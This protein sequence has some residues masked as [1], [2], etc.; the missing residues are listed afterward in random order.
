[1][2]KYV[3]QDPFPAE[4]W[5][6]TRDALEFGP[7]AAQFDMLTEI[8]DGSDDCLYLNVYTQSTETSILRPVMFW[9]HG[10]GFIFGS[11][12]DLFYGPDY[13]M[14]KDIVLV[15]VNYRLGVFGEDSISCTSKYILLR[16]KLILLQLELGFLNLEDKVAPGNQGLKDQVMALQWVHD[17]IKSFGGDPE[18]VTI[19]GE[20]AGGASVHYLTMSPLARGYFLSYNDFQNSSSFIKLNKSL[21]D[22]F[23]RQYLK[24]ELH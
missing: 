24:V 21:Q 17:N 4:A 2:W 5:K 15:T 22:F 14:K 10:G 3:L 12:N 19:F 23:T 8:S 9:I 13:L 7:I 11:G 20:S 16:F 6:G 1:M 18:N